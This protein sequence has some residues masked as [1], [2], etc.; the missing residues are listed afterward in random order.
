MNGSNKHITLCG[1]VAGSFEN[2]RGHYGLLLAFIG[3][4]V[5]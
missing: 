5:S 1:S 4:Y 3:G 2:G